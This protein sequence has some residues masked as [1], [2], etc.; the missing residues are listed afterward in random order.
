MSV[1]NVQFMSDINCKHL[2]S[3]LVFQSWVT[4]E[5]GR[6]TPWTVTGIPVFIGKTQVFDC[7]LAIFRLQTFL[8]VGD[9]REHC[10]IPILTMLMLEEG[11][12]STHALSLSSIRLKDLSIWV[13]LLYL[14]IQTLWWYSIN[15]P[16]KIVS[17]VWLKEISA[18]LGRVFDNEASK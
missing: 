11:A 14:K 12:I 8:L 16:P 2:Y 18:I 1:I 15:N 3:S 9:A 4:V 5:F 7:D 17:R 13:H 10:Q 6:K